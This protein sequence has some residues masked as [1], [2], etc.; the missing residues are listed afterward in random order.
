M[1]YQCIYPLSDERWLEFVSANELANI[2][3][4]PAWLRVIGGQYNLSPQAFCT[5]ENGK[6]VNGFIFMTG[7]DS[8]TTA[9]CS[10]SNLILGNTNAGN[11]VIANF[12]KYLGDANIRHVEFRDPFPSP[13]LYPAFMGYAHEV[14]IDSCIESVNSR[15]VMSVSRNIRLAVKKGLQYEIRNDREAVYEFYKL[16]L[17]IRKKFGIAVEPIGFFEKFYDEIIKR[18]MG[19]AVS[20]TLEGIPISCGLFAGFNTT[21]AYK[22]GASDSR[23]LP[24]RPNNLML[25]AA[26]LEGQKRN[27][28]VFDM[29]RT[30]KDNEGLR[31]FKLSWGCSE[32]PLYFNYYPANPQNNPLQTVNQLLLKPIIRN[33]PTIVCRLTGKLV[34]RLFP[35]KFV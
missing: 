31:R 27:F 12:L 22:Y 23:L 14:T 32:T 15:S 29:G 35:L 16:H 17:S 1:K 11:E 25:W 26:L 4:H 28:K 34:Y 10:S 7:K 20:V 9:S 18:G 19:F 21:L 24:Y 30:E 6:I 8:A 2:H 3:H 33:T 13:S 5:I